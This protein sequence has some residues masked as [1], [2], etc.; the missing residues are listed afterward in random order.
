MKKLFT[1]ALVLLIAALG[2]GTAQADD[3]LARAN[4]AL[5]MNSISADS[6][7]DLINWQVG[8]SM[9]YTLKI[10]P[11]G[12]GTMHKFVKSEDKEQHAIW[13]R[14]D[15]AIMGQNQNVEMLMRRSDAKILKVLQ[16]GQ[17]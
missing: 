14:Q 6:A 10:G 12:S 13:I 11:M 3:G 16:N 9:D 5:L 17:E 1:T 4:L 2:T 8:E 7:R 15:I